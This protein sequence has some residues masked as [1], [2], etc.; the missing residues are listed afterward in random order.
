M[1]EEES[2]LNIVGFE[3]IVEGL[4]GV[5]C[6]VAS[7]LVPI[8]SNAFRFQYYQGIWA[9]GLVSCAILLEIISTCLQILNYDIQ[10]LY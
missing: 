3:L 8:F 10:Y 9:G 4:I 1:S 6:G 5:G 2:I 7:I